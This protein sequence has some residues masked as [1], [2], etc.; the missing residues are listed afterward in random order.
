MR[1]SSHAP[2]PLTLVA[3]LLLAAPLSF[4]VGCCHLSST[5]HH[6]TASRRNPLILLRLSSCCC[7]SSHCCL[8]PLPSCFLVGCHPCCTA[9]PPL[10]RSLSSCP[11]CSLFSCCILSAS[12]CN[13]PPLVVVFVSLSSLQ[14]GRHHHGTSSQDGDRPLSLPITSRCPLALVV[15]HHWPSLLPLLLRLSLDFALAGLLCLQRQLREVL[16]LEKHKVEG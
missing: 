1:L 13:A 4:S 12:C 2:A 3:P 7:L 14:E 10:A 6:A 5:C 16:S 11:S 9:C 15:C 8:L